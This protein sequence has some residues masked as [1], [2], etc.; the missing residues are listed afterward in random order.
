MNNITKQGFSS[1]RRKQFGRRLDTR[2]SG[3]ALAKVR[4]G[5]LV[6]GWSG[7]FCKC[8]PIEQARL[9]LQQLQ[10]RLP[11]P[12]LHRA[13]LP[14][15][16][17]RLGARARQLRRQLR[18]LG[19]PLRPR[20]APRARTSA[21]ARVAAA[22]SSARRQLRRQGVPLRPESAAAS[23]RAPAPPP[24]RGWRP[25][26]PLPGA[27]PARAA[28]PACAPSRR[29]RRGPALEH[30]RRWSRRGCARQRRSGS[31]DAAQ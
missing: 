16:A 14:R 4:E 27:P 20:L 25:P 31:P 19:V 2:C 6:W 3:V 5:W 18:R 13:Q 22:P 29:G 8:F 26:P 11:L 12:P 9:P 7:V 17:L 10:A 21:D 30:V 28:P 24:T 1:S 15:R 23:R